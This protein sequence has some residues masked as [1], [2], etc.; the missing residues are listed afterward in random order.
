MTV[1]FSRRTCWQYLLQKHDVRNIRHPEIAAA[2]F[3][4]QPPLFCISIQGMERSSQLRSKSPLL[5]GFLLPHG[6]KR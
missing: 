3:L 6:C 4:S 5:T 2:P 1:K